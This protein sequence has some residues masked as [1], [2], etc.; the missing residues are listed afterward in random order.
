MNFKKTLKKATAFTLSAMLTLGVF[1]FGALGDMTTAQ[2]AEKEITIDFSQTDGEMVPKTGWLLIPNESLPDGRIIP[3]NTKD[4]R[5]DM[6]TQN[7]LGNN[8]N[9]NGEDCLVDVIPN[10]R[11]R[12]QRAKNGIERLHDLG[13][14]NYYPIMAYM[15]SW[16]GA[17]GKPQ[18]PPKD[19]ETWK[20]WVKDIVQ[21]MKDNDLGVTEYNVYNENWNIS[22]DNFNRMYEQAW[23]AGK[24]VMPESQMIGP[25]PSSDNASVV[26]SLADY[27]EEVGIPLD[28][29]AWHFGNINNI[30]N[31]QQSLEDYISQK[32]SL[33]NPKY[34][35]EEYTLS[36]NVNKMSAEF[37]T[38][39]NFDRADIDAAIRG[40][41]SYVN[42]LSDM[43]ICD[44]HA[45]NPYY[46]QKIWWQMTA[47]GAMSGIRV[48]QTGDDLYVA[49][50]DEEKGEAK[51]LIGNQ[52]GDVTINMSN[53]P[54]EGANV[55][56]DK[57]RL[58]DIENDGLQYQESDEAAVAGD[59]VSTKV[60]FANTSDVWMLVV[61]KAES[62]PSD[63]ALMGPDDGMNAGLSPEF[64]WQVSQGATSYDF[65]IS[66]SKD[67]SDPVYS[68]TGITEN[69][70]VLE[71]P[72]EA[73]ETYYWTVTAQNKYGA[74]EAYN[75]MYYSLVATKDTGI[76][77]PF[78]MLQVIDGD[79][80]TELTPKI[81]WKEAKD[82]EK[83]VIS[84]SEQE[85]FSN[86][87]TIEVTNPPSHDI[88]L[89]HKY[90]YYT[91]TEE[92]AL[93]ATTH[94]YIKV[95]AV[96]EYGVR[97][98]NGKVHE[99]TTATADGKP[100]AFN[101]TTPG[102]GETI[103][104]RSTLRWEQSLSGFFYRLEIASDPDFEN[105]VLQRDTITVPAYTLEEDVLEP[106][107]TYYWRVTAV[108][109]DGKQETEC[110]NGVQSFIMSKAPAAPIVK[111]AYSAPRGVVVSF[112]GVQEADS[113]VVKYGVSSGNYTQSVTTN[114][115]EVYIP[116]EGN[117]TYYFSVASVRDGVESKTYNEVSAVK[118]TPAEIVLD[119]KIEIEG[120]SSFDKAEY[121]LE[122]GA[123][124][125]FAVNFGAVE[126][127]TEF[128][129]MINCDKIQ[130]AYQADQDTSV[131]VYVN[132]EKITDV[133]L[134]DTNG[135]Y[136]TV[137]IAADC[138][139]GDTLAFQKDTNEAAF[140]LDYMVLS[141][142][143][144]LENVALH[145]KAEANSTLRNY[146]ADKAVDGS[147]AEPNFW[148]STEKITADKPNW[149]DVDLGGTAEIYSINISL[150]DKPHWTERTQNIRILAITDG[151][152][153]EEIV[154]RTDYTFTP[155]DSGNNNRQTIAL[156]EP[157]KA[158]HIKVEIYSN[159]DGT[160][161]GVIG[162]LE[163]M[164]VMEPSG[165]EEDI[166][167][168]NLALKKPVIGSEKFD[169]YGSLENC[170]DG[171]LTTFFDC[172]NTSVG[173]HL[174]YSVTVDLGKAYALD[175]TVF[176]L[177]NTWVGEPRTQ[178]LA[179]ETSL[180]GIDFTT[181]ME[182]TEYY[183][184]V[185]DNNNI[186]EVVLPEGTAGRY[187]R[188]TCTDMNVPVYPLP[189]GFQ[190]AEL[191]VYGHYG[192]PTE[193]VDVAPNA[194]TVKAYG[195]KQLKAVVYPADAV[196]PLVSWSSNNV[197][198]V[199]VDKRTGVVTGKALG[200]AGVRARTLDGNF[201]DTSTVTVVENNVVGTDIPA[202]YLPYGEELDP[203]LLPE[204]AKVLLEDNGEVMA[205]I[206]GWDL[207]GLDL[208]TAGAH[209]IYSDLEE[210]DLV[211]NS[212]NI[213]AELTIEVVAPEKK[214]LADLYNQWKDLTEQGNY[215]DTTWKAFTDAIEQAKTVL[216]SDKVT[217]EQVDSA[218]ADL[219]AAAE[220]LVAVDKSALKALYEQCEDITE[221]GDY[222]DTTWNEFTEAKAEAFAALSNGDATQGQVNDA[223][224]KLL[225]ARTA[226][227]EKVNKEL[228]IYAIDL[229]E[230]LDTADCSAA[231]VKALNDAVAAAK[232]TLKNDKA[233]EADVTKAVEDIMN[234]IAGLEKVDKAYLENLVEMASGLSKD[235]YTP[236]TWNAMQEKLTAAKNILGTDNASQD[237]VM[238]AY[239]E[240]LNAV[241]GLKNRAETSG[242]KGAM[243]MIQN[244]LDNADKYEAS[245]I[246]GLSDLLAQAEKL[247][248]DPNA[249]QQD[250]N[251]MIEKLLKAIDNAELVAGSGDNNGSNDNSSS[252][253]G[254]NNG[255]S[256]PESTNK[257]QTGDCFP[258]VAGIV[259][260]ITA[261][262]CL[263]ALV[264]LRKRGKTE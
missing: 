194:V 177:P 16:V 223:F 2:A 54:F 23:W 94:Y 118:G 228:L 32:P 5:D 51:I 104:Q 184:S 80:G 235:N 182:N 241:A 172:A 28:I 239:A 132:G 144:A 192:A 139:N 250:V 21:Y 67:M 145:K 255:S 229:A 111:V 240:L 8:A 9:N 37:I 141:E 243:D 45:D 124:A 89:Q 174:P 13:V 142:G 201:T 169:G 151:E 211:N 101:T 207:E 70:Y 55:R 108:S 33:G 79:F 170:V 214:D 40:I 187:V 34:Y 159:T 3:L 232:E 138:E 81:S 234:A 41:W 244:I 149:L 157:V 105:V 14:D 217:Q 53:F 264:V 181:V 246:A 115:T 185:E 179:I 210:I 140:T 220:G 22:V 208:T 171:K 60:N 198:I 164:G 226:L 173:T 196:N 66:K 121:K 26:Y 193:S 50:Y 39:A 129:P 261:L 99:F 102:D 12:L 148:T 206:T 18:G 225:A 63:F 128:T 122:S 4:V 147:F 205:G 61:K 256:D 188:V 112:D 231:S 247:Y 199:I 119:E 150:V 136:S 238:K 166:S 224:T 230:K 57:Y 6:D 100:A 47:Y 237:Q 49:S 64:S 260:G 216:D 11:N 190:L 123:S 96:N 65:V 163:V 209:T 62:I 200:E 203:A 213:R 162:E 117:G 86:A 1:S 215:T 253:N 168:V 98:M 248:N 222:T 146:T 17:N 262:G 75:G 202:I 114:D 130:L 131:A 158:S 251:A 195:Q 259:M 10:E 90:V 24:E 58:T 35:Y 263:G 83:Y 88:G 52:T 161:V 178:R 84:I 74:R 155:G 221:Q 160:N 219:K 125:G 78:T 69:K 85:D 7:L 120:A 257:P 56:V 92:E 249:S 91:L 19:Y 68:K 254:E 116:L 42:G 245:S 110:E 15:P 44:Q 43:V 176:K 113:Y 191:E 152:E 87:Q 153:Y 30:P 127:K 106:E 107:K 38:L 258:L 197:D 82:A 175:K 59:T 212:K 126:S 76:P 204:K 252:N 233:T 72:L 134:Y 31:F 27:C 46:R 189:V 48:K 137:E 183:F 236:A 20:Q 167:G 103:E 218:I 25:S 180:D 143:I 186:N 135:Q 154:P 133:Q 109:K 165:T 71:V 156:K 77:G 73:G 36:G 97:S 29:V 93:K 242:L 227:T 95:D